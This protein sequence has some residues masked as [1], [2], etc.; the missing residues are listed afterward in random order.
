MMMG[1]SMVAGADAEVDVAEAESH[2]AEDDEAEGEQIA[3]VELVGEKADKRHGDDGADTS[4]GHDD[5]GGESGIA[6]QLL[7]EE[8][9]NA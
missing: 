7:I 6:E 1:H 3:R 2:E 4:R 9:K 5:A 8:G